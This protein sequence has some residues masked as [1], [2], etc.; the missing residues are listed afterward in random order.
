MCFLAI[1]RWNNAGL[2]SVLYKPD[3]KPASFRVGLTKTHV[4]VYFD[5]SDTIKISYSEP[6][7]ISK[8][9]SLFN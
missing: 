1:P 9:I 7:Y 5:K 4:T 3:I 6:D 8:V 2:L